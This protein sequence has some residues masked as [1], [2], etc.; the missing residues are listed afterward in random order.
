M[1]ELAQYDLTAEIDKIIEVTGEPKVTYAGYSQGAFLMFYGLA[2]FGE[3][4][5]GNKVNKF[6]A[7]SP[8]IYVQTK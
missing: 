4:Y 3:E 7:L 5:F 6:I 8:C 1:T 2:K